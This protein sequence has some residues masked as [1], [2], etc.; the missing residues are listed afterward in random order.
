M[1]D[2]VQAADYDQ[3]MSST[4][5]SSDLTFF[6]GVI[7]NVLEEIA[8]TGDHLLEV[9]NRETLRLRLSAAIFKCAEGGERDAERLR[10][11]V[12]AMVAA[13]LAGETISRGPQGIG[14][15]A[16]A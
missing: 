2:G 9:A 10:R 7:D 1:A 3:I 4:Y 6:Q 13:P 14:P 11:H 8:G 16:T 5:D 15:T 12:M